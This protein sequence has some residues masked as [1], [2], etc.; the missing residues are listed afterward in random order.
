MRLGGTSTRKRLTAAGSTAILAGMAT[1]AL[2]L[3][4]GPAA[5]DSQ[6]AVAADYTCTGGPVQL[7]QSDVTVDVSGSL[8]AS[9]QVGDKPSL[10]GFQVKVTVPEDTA[11]ALRTLLITSIDG[12]FTDFPV[13]A[14]SGGGEGAAGAANPGAD[15]KMTIGT[16]SIPAEGGFTFT[17]PASAITL[18]PFDAARPGNLAVRVNEFRVALNLNLA[19]AA[20]I[21]ANFTCTGDPIQVASVNVKEKPTP[22]TPT[23][24][25]STNPQGPENPGK[26]SDDNSPEPSGGPTTTPGGTGNDNS[27]DTTTPPQARPE[28]ANTGMPYTI[29]MTATGSALVLLGAG[30]VVLSRRRA[31]AAALISDETGTDTSTD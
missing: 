18:G 14:F 9:V 10:S 19:G 8:P 23:G 24:K 20:P 30:M 7:E 1:A 29:P 31:M 5:A 2:G 15:G 13:A 3:T 27:N 6:A 17:S 4:A 12:S 21:P 26:P 25:P 11:A 28:L 22:P 16:T